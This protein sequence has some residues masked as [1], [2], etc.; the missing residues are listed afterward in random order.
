MVMHLR[1]VSLYMKISNIN[2]LCVVLSFT[3]GYSAEE[4]YRI[5]MRHRYN[6][7]VEM[8]LEHLSHEVHSIKVC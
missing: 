4:K 2:H 1:T 7:C 3:G 6:S 5:F 8:L